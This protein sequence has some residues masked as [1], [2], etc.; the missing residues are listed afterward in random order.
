M[1]GLFKTQYSIG[2]SILTLDEESEQDGSDSVFGIAKREGLEEIYLVEDGMSGFLKAYEN[3]KKLGI[4]LRFG[5]R[6]SCVNSL[7]SEDDN[8]HK[9]VLFANNSEGCNKL[10]KIF[11]DAA[12]KLSKRKY[13]TLDMDYLRSVWTKDLS[14]IIPFYDSFLFKN[15]LTF[16]E[17]VPDYSFAEPTFLKEDN[18]LPFEIIIHEALKAYEKSN[19]VLLAKSIYYDK[20][21]HFDAWQTFKIICNRK[22]YGNPTLE[23]P[24]MEHCSS[25]EFCVESW[26]D[27]K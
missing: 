1:L 23:A 2:K 18:N 11:S 16:S 15:C 12:T 4:K 20:K 5:L 19:E 8:F 6:I 24:N 27:K 9:I 17:F 25:N 10:I 22:G 13:P 26:K 14:L 21:E 3:S 7:S